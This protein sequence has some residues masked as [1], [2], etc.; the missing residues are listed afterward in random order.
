M[1]TAVIFIL[2]QPKI[3]VV[4]VKQEADSTSASNL[5]KLNNLDYLDTFES[6]TSAIDSSS[7]DSIGK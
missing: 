6:D 3:D 1:I 7:T 2:K 4:Q 5:D